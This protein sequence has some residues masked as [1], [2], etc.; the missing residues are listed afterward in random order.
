MAK[1]ISDKTVVT[2]LLLT[3]IIVIIGAVIVYTEIK[4]AST[5]DTIPKTYASNA[6][7]IKFYIADTKENNMTP[8]SEYTNNTGKK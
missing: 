4:N 3:A 8:D 1:D 7:R 2:V 6:G 5:A